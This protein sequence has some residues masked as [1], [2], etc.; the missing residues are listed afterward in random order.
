MSTVAVATMAA[1]RWARAVLVLLCM[2]RVNCVEDESLGMVRWRKEAFVVG[3]WMRQSATAWEWRRAERRAPREGREEVRDAHCRVESRRGCGGVREERRAERRRM[4]SRR[5]GGRACL[6]G[7]LRLGRVLVV[8]VG[9]SGFI[10]REL[11]ALRRSCALA[12]WRRADLSAWSQNIS[13]KW[14]TKRW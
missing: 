12:A 10:S 7:G 2:E 11:R 6:A 9:V 8:G 14:E 13:E 3:D 4:S 1:R 5:S